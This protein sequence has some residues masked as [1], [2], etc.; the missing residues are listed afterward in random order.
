VTEPASFY[1]EVGGDAAFRRLVDLFYERVEKDPV[2]RPMYPEADLGPARHRMTT[3]LAQYW[4]GPTT[5][6]DERGHPRLRL[7][8]SGFPIDDEARARWLG[9]MRHAIDEWDVSEGHRERMWT[10]LDRAA[11]TLVNR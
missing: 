2:L 10:Y 5:Y 9:H 7:R 11:P 1:E 3:F 6:G 8:H 4:G